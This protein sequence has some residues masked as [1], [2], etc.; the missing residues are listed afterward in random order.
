MVEDS[1]RFFSPLPLSETRSPKTS[2]RCSTGRW[3][4]QRAARFAEAEGAERRRCWRCGFLGTWT[5]TNPVKSWT[6]PSIVLDLNPGSY[7][8]LFNA[9]NIGF[10]GFWD[11]SVAAWFFHV[12]H[13]ASVQ[14]HAFHFAHPTLCRCAGAP[15]A[16]AHANQKDERRTDGSFTFSWKGVWLSLRETEP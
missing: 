6:N 8:T 12:A 13:V 11:W 7:S 5:W 14:V 9:P 4:S 15:Q 10:S 2:R 1:V 3:H 16:S